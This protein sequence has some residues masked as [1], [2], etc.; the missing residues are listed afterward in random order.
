M[1]ISLIGSTMAIALALSACG[2]MGNARDDDG[3]VSNDPTPSSHSYP[4]TGFTGVTLAGP[5][6]VVIHRGDQFS[7]TASGPRS[8]L[9]RLEV[10]VDDGTLKVQRRSGNGMWGSSHGVATITVTMPALST[11]VI[12]GSGNGIADG[13]SGDKG[14]IVVAGSGDAQV[15]GLQVKALKL[16]VAG[17]GDIGATG[18]ADSAEVTIAGSGAVDAPQLSSGS[19][20]ISIIGSGDIAMAVHGNAAVSLAGSGGVTLTGGAHCT[21]SRVGSGSVTCS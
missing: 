17:S 2:A 5:D 8:A 21:T 16:T 1:R 11:L 7:V 12:A 10:A 9:D 13:M 18:T 15:N 6:N 14:E 19:A 3:P 4:L 20:E